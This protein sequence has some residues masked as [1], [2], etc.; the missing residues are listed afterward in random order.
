MLLS[1][2][3]GVPTGRQHGLFPSRPFSGTQHAEFNPNQSIPKQR[4]RSARPSPRPAAADRR[5][6]VSCP[7]RAT[8]PP[9]ISS[10]RPPVLALTCKS[11]GANPGMQESD[12][13]GK[14]GRR[15]WVRVFWR[16]RRRCAPGRRANRSPVER[17]GLF[18]GARRQRPRLLQLVRRAV[19]RCQDQRRRDRPAGRCAPP[20][21][22]TSAFRHAGPMGSDRPH[23]QRE[24]DAGDRRDRGRCSNIPTTTSATGSAP[25]AG[26]RRGPCWR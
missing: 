15:L 7:S 23:G 17:S 9:G 4:R 12:V 16:A 1:S 14:I 13:K 19:R 24:V 18:R 2:P 6:H 3:A 10:P 22:A 8:A 11:A 20:P 26:G 25:S 21:T 5:L